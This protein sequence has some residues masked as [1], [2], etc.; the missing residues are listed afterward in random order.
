MKGGSLARASKSLRSGQ[1]SGQSSCST[2]RLRV[3]MADQFDAKQVLDFPLLPVDG[4]NGVGQRRQFR[5]VRR[6]GNAHQDKAVRGVQ[7]VEVIDKKNIVPG[8]GV[9]GKKAGEAA[10]VLFVKRG[11]EG[12]GQFEFGV[13]VKLVGLRGARVF[14]LR[15]ETARQLVQH[16]LQA[17]EQVGAFHLSGSPLLILI[18]SLVLIP[19]IVFI[20]RLSIHNSAVSSV[21]YDPGRIS[22]FRVPLLILILPMNLAGSGVAP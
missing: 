22:H 4:V 9:L 13:Q 14:D 19:K 21:R 8:A 2:Q 17:G 11:A 10:V 20:S 16:N 3:G 6:D 18:P 12:A 1:T 5:F 7:R 15:A